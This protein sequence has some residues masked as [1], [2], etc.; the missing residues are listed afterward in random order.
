MTPGGELTRE[1][2]EGFLHDCALAY[3]ANGLAGRGGRFIV[4]L[5]GRTSTAHVMVPGE[6]PVAVQMTADRDVD[7][8][9]YLNESPDHEGHVAAIVRAAARAV[10]G[11]EAGVVPADAM[12][13]LKN[14]L[15][16]CGFVR[17]DADQRRW[18]NCYKEEAKGG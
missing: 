7:G 4:K 14:R 6:E 12:D 2:V 17:W 11:T 3:V 5:G 9:R 15:V 13:R 10:L 16:A 8:A 1:M 18:V